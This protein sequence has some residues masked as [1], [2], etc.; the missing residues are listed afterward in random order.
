M[1]RT[2]AQNRQGETKLSAKALR[3]LAAHD[4]EAEMRSTKTGEPAEA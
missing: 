4:R 3:L 2:V 1:V